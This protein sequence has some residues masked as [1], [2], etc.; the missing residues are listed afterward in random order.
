MEG[1][2]RVRRKKGGGREGGRGGVIAR[3]R[4]A[5]WLGGRNYRNCFPHNGQKFLPLPPSP[6]REHRGLR[7]AAIVVL[8]GRN[9]SLTRGGANKCQCGTNASG[10]EGFQVLV[11]FFLFP[12]TTYTHKKKTKAAMTRREIIGREEEEI[13]FFPLIISRRI[14][15]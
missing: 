2:G 12:A 4:N 8:V 5:E 14:G 1:R 6:R 10:K 7:N 15:H 11:F 13:V 9:V 3:L